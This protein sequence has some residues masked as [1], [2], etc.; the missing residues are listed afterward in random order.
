MK[1]LVFGSLNIDKVYSLQKLPEKGET[2]SCEKYELHV[3]GKGLN[4]AVS[5][6]KSEV[7]V[8]MAGCV[9]KDGK[10]LTDFLSASGVD[11]GFVKVSDGFTGHA[12]IEVDKDGQNQMILFKGANHEITKADC[13]AVL[14]NFTKGDLIILQYETS[15][16]EYM[17]NKA[18]EKGIKI[19]L[20]PSPYV[21]EIINLPLNKVDFL[22]LNESEGMSISKRSTVDDA[23]SELKRI[24]PDSSIIMTLGADGAIYAD[25]EKYVKVPA[26]KVNAV[27]TTGAGDT[28]T[29]YFLN[30]FLANADPKHALI[31]ASAASAIVVGKCG[32]A[33]TIPE[34]AE[35]E[36]FLSEN[37]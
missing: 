20:N 33:E 36:K 14:E 12:V 2:L 19:A 7:Q 23:V 31:K 4:Q 10:M 29:G 6:S 17:I 32:A 5:L 27:D 26:F 8:Y 1:Y 25:S 9:G 24:C 35:V 15:N 22:I 13:D 28:F 37:K 16:V 11:T 21:E 18:H 30:D 3:G 34:N